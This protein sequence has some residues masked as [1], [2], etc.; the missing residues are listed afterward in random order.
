MVNVLYWDCRKTKI[1]ERGRNVDIQK[2]FWLQRAQRDQEVRASSI[3]FL[4]LADYPNVALIASF[5]GTSL[6]R[7]TSPIPVDQ[8]GPSLAQ[9]PRTEEEPIPIQ[10]SPTL[11]AVDAFGFGPNACKAAPTA[12][13]I[14]FNAAVGIQHGPYAKLLKSGAAAW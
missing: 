7:F 14:V 2:E 10:C 8:S 12:Q 1:E 13:Q 4:F 5:Y 9:G 6:P 11:P 3:R